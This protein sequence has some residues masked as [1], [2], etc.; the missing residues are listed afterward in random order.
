[1]I[2]LAYI[3]KWLPQEYSIF[4]NRRSY[5]HRKCFSMYFGAETF[6]LPTEVFPL[7]KMPLRQQDPYLAKLSWFS[8]AAFASHCTMYPYH[9]QLLTY[10]CWSIWFPPPKHRISWGLGPGLT[11]LFIIIQYLTQNEDP[12]YKGMRFII[13][14]HL[15]GSNSMGFRVRWAGF[16]WKLCHVPAWQHWARYL[17]FLSLNFVIC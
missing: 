17:M 13:K 3:A 10:R 7:F 2:W 5:L 11:I 16:K 12:A 14:I 8:Q 6:S 1:M 4:S 9:P 15:M